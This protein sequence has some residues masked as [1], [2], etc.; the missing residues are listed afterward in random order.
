MIVQASFASPFGFLAPMVL[1][2][3]PVSVA[4][5]IAPP[6]IPPAP[7]APVAPPME[8]GL[9]ASRAMLRGAS[10]SQW[11][12]RKFDAEASDQVIRQHG[13]AAN[14]GRFNKALIPQEALAPIRAAATKIRTVHKRWTRPWSD[15]GLDILPSANVGQYD[16]D[17]TPAR[18]DFEA[19]VEAFLFVYPGLVANAPARLSGLYSADDYPSVDEL[20]TRFGLRIRTL[21]LPTAADFRVEMSEAQSRMIR[22]EI[23]ADLRE[24]MADAMRATWRDV[25]KVVGTMAEKLTAYRPSTGKGDRAEFAFHDSLVEHVRTLVGLLPSFN[26]VDDPE[27]AAMGARME[28]ELCRHDATALK[29]DATL[30]QDT[31]KAAEA[32]LAD[33]SAFL[34]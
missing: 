24:T 12:G 25:A 17:M 14:S 9:L 28:R 19:A 18:R 26:L 16:A 8:P 10:V 27:L 30:R 5:P 33:V 6:P 13:A 23:E 1:A 7:V 34:A 4:E 32:I 3:E 20:R 15:K 11:D 22:E 31:A 21:P 2:P 29:A